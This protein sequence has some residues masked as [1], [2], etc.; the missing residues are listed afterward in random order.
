MFFKVTN[1]QPLENYI[2]LV[3]F[4]NGV[5]KQYDIKPLFEK[6]HVFNQ[7]KQDNLY[8]Y[9]K[10]DAGGYGI[11]WNAEIDLSANE[12]WENGMPIN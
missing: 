12:L 7:L 10:V 4:E 8:K 1:V 6:W 11:S 5:K 3:D 9:V 2:L